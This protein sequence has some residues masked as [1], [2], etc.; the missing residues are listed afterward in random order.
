MRGKKQSVHLFLWGGVL[1]VA[2][3]LGQTVET[4]NGV[5]LI[6]N[7]KEGLWGKKPRV[8]LRLVRTLGDVNAEDENVAFYMPSGIAMDSQGNLYVLDTGN[9]RIQKFGPEGTYLATIGRQGQGPGEFSY[10]DSIDI[11]K[12]DRIWVSDPHNQ[13]IQ[14]LTAEGEEEKTLSFI[15]ERVGHIRCTKSG[16][17]MAGGMRGFLALG[18]GM[19]EEPKNVPPLFKILDRDGKVLGEYGEPHDFKHTLLNAAANQVKFAVDEG[20]AVYLAYLYQNRVEKYSPEGKLLWR[21]DRKL[22]YSLDLPKDKGK[23]EAK[24]GGISVRMPRLNQ[25]ANGIAVDGAGRVWVVTLTRQPREEEQVGVA[26]SVRARGGERQ[27]S[28]KVQGNT[29]AETTDMYKLEIFSPD[30]ELLGSLAVNHF[31]DG[32]SIK[33]SR[34]FLWDGLRRAKF[35]EYA[36]EER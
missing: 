2:L 11:D 24:G 6:H 13:R 23:M 14:V 10:P 7:G 33:G 25:C 22:D 16:L 35:F 4:V 17:V 36:I 27:M 31:V 26:M 18:P 8:H 12:A 34:L 21:A 28:M 20:G 32:I 9:H 19:K 5:R 29:E 1:A 30:G 15:E 3:T